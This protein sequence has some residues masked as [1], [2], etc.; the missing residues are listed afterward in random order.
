MKNALGIIACAA[1]LA[2]APAQAETIRPGSL[3]PAAVCKQGNAYQD[4]RLCPPKAQAP[5]PAQAPSA[6]SAPAVP[7]PGLPGGFGLPFL[8]GMAASL[9]LALLAFPLFLARLRPRVPKAPDMR[10]AE[11][12]KTRQ[13][14]YLAAR[15]AFPEWIVSPASRPADHF[16]LSEEAGSKPMAEISFAA[17]PPAGFILLNKADATPIAWIIA[18]G[19]DTLSAR[20]ALEQAAIPAARL[21]MHKGAQALRQAAA[22]ALRGTLF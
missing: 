6:Q 12:D 15:E 22:V 21:P 1:A 14:A 11:L 20:L 16:A 3:D 19:D 2:C 10:R 9:A 18:E 4:A 13:E 17:L 8:A 5:A 7:A